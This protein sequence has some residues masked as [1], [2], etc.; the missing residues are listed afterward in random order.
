MPNELLNLVIAFAPLFSKPTFNHVK[1]LLVGAILSPASRTVTNALR[2]VGLSQEKHFQNYH[3]VLNRASWSC[4]NGSRIL[5]KLLLK[6][7]SLGDEIVIGFDDHL[8]R[9]RGKRIKAK[10]IYRDAVRSSDSF[11]VKA[12]GL[13]W[14]SFMLLTEVPFARRIW[15]LPFLTVICPSE[16]YHLE[17]GIRHRNLTDR[18]RQAIVQ[19][20][21][22][23]PAQELIFVGD[24]S[25][26]A[27]DLLNAVREKVTV[28]TKL[29]LDAA[30]YE[31]APKRI[32]GQPGRPRKKG[33]RLPTLKEASENPNTIWEKVTVNW[34]GV[35]KEIET[36][37]G[38]CVWFHFGK[39]AVPIRWVTVRD[40]AGEFDTQAL[41]CTNQEAEPKQIVE[42]F[43]RRWQVEVTFEESRRHLGI[44]TNRQWSDNAINRTTPSLFGLFSLITLM[45][46]ELQK[47]DKLKVRN[48]AWYEKE[49]ATFSD[50]IG[51]VRQQIWEFQSFQTSENEYEVIKIPR[52]FLKTLTDTLCFVA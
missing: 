50:A 4:L 23:F 30:L 18:A 28:V 20:W 12:S 44:E 42:W 9:R 41:L 49:V 19:I 37:S 33:K 5:L 1:V 2:V 48:V 46:N 7:F 52:S 26:A 36:T 11:F 38:T 3:R 8:E 16:R 13:R 17:K 40:L 29:R 31:V 35:E 34:Y 24:S 32:D 45:A 39:E 14:L 27:I 6:A 15:A 51:C 25:Y 10:G 22:W 43:I 47:G 21:R